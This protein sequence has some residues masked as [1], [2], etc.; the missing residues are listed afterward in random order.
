MERKIDIFEDLDGKKIVM[1]HD[2]RFKEKLI[3]RR[4]KAIWRSM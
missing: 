3:G 2:I 1:I 4:W